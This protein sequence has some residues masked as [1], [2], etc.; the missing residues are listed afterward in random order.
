MVFILFLKQN[1]NEKILRY[2]NFDA[3]SSSNEN[4]FVEH[5]G[6]TFRQSI[7]ATREKL[8]NARLK[9]HEI[10]QLK[11]LSHRLDGFQMRMQQEAERQKLGAKKKAART[12]ETNKNVS[13]VCWGAFRW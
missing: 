12:Y 5:M 3:F 2:S 11:K 6:A 1:K 7:L 13:Q 8:I 9:I 4:L 10:L